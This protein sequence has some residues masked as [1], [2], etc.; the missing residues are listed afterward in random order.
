MNKRMGSRFDCITLW[1]T[2]CCF[3]LNKKNT[4]SFSPANRIASLRISALEHYIV[5]PT[6]LTQGGRL[7][8]ISFY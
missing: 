8:T 4:V 2:D 5:A 3:R 6:L 1:V 7:V